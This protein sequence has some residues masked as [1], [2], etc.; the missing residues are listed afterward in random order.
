M[1]Y[2]DTVGLALGMGSQVGL[3]AKGVNGGNVGLDGVE[4][5]AADWLIG[6]NVTT[7]SRQHSV[8]GGDA[9]GGGADL[10]DQV[11]LHQPRGRHQKC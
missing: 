11:R 7:S 5:R 8:H 6:N 1:F 9:I 4:G 10:T 2:L 3:K